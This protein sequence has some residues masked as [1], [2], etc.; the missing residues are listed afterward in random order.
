MAVRGVVLSKL[1]SC[2]RDT[3]LRLAFQ[4]PLQVQY[5]SPRLSFLR[6]L[7]KILVEPLGGS[8]R[9]GHKHR[10]YCQAFLT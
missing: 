2:V 8:R 1:D 9:S 10:F 7:Y 3:S 5:D 6:T 4:R